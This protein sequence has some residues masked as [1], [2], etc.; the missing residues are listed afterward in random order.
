MPL[1]PSTPDDNSLLPPL[2]DP[3]FDPL[4]SELDEYDTP[5]EVRK[6][7]LAAFARHHAARQA[8]LPWWR[9]LASPGWQLAGGGAALAAVL[10]TV[11]VTTSMRIDTPAEPVTA[12]EVGK[13]A[14]LGDFIALAS[15]ERI[16]QDPAPRMLATTIPRTSLS[17]L[18]VAVDPQDAGDLVQ[19]EMLVGADGSP[20]ALRLGLQ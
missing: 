18:G 12:A 3:L 14:A 9:R 11:L 13:S 10:V 5:P 16:E 1:P 2:R 19:A 6:Q 20:L 15:I 4:R 7:L 17:A 8:A